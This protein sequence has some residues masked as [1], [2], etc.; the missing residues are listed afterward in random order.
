[1]QPQTHVQTQMTIWDILGPIGTIAKSAISTIWHITTMLPHWV[2]IVFALAIVW[3]I[4]E[5]FK[6][7]PQR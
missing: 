7:R 6:Q 2:L 1:M 3:R 4:R 5:M